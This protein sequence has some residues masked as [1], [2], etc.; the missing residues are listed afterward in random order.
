MERHR[1]QFASTLVLAFAL[2]AAGGCNQST[3]TT[4]IQGTTGTSSAQSATG[5]TASLSTAALKKLAASGDAKA[6]ANLG[7]AY[8]QGQG[9]IQDYA[10]AAAWYRKAAAQGVAGAQFNLGLLYDNGQGV[11]QSYAQAAAWYRKAARS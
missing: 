4:A 1:K 2:I 6:Q 5:T 10:Q 9:V 8:D 3:G 7:L 11:Q